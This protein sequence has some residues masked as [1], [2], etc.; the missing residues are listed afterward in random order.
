MGMR[1]LPQKHA[2]T[3]L[4]R[5]T[6]WFQNSNKRASRSCIF[7]AD[8]RRCGCLQC[9]KSTSLLWQDVLERWKCTVSVMVEAAE[10]SLLCI[11]TFADSR[12]RASQ[13]VVQA[14]SSSWEP[15]YTG[16]WHLPR[17]RH[18]AKKH[19]K[20]MEKRKKTNI[21]WNQTELTCPQSFWHF[22]G[23]GMALWLEGRLRLWPWCQSHAS[24]E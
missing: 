22:E 9:H 3:F 20:K 15:L 18:N 10:L 13:E 23:P 16:C 1:Q 11:S 7:L 14:Q 21:W 8:I 17:R 24:R 2:K 12:A 19:R 5:K 6:L 4:C